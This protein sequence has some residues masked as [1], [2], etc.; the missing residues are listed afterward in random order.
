MGALL[1]LL[2]FLDDPGDPPALP[3]AHRPRLDD[4]HAIADFHVVAFVVRQKLRRALLG[5]AVER[6]SNLPLDGNH[7]ALVHLVA[8]DTPGNFRFRGHF[9]DPGSFAPAVPPRL[10]LAAPQRPAP[11]RRARPWRA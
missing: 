1:N 3:P 10:A 8:D 5:L 7:D 2:G 4:C 6:V 9:S 11:R